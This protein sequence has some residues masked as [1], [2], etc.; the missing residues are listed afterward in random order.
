MGPVVSSEMLELVLAV[1]S[2]HVITYP[3]MKV[4]KNESYIVNAT[5]SKCV[6]CATNRYSLPRQSK[7]LDI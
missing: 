6:Q 2:Y 4:Y 1:H 7:K 5:Q 3:G